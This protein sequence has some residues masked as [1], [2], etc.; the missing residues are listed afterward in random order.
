MDLQ[1][2][3]ALSLLPGISRIRAAAVFKDLRDSSGNR[4]F[5]LEDDVHRA[6]SNGEQRHIFLACEECKQP[7]PMRPE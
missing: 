7:S 2:S 4:A 5:A 1:T 3:V 6:V